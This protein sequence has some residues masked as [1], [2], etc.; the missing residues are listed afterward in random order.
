MTPRGGGG[1]GDRGRER[2]LRS[3]TTLAELMLV[4]W[5]FAFVLLALARFS[6][7]QARLAAATAH[8]LRAEEV[9][10]VAGVVLGRELRALAV[11]DVVALSEDSVRIRAVRG[12]GPVCGGGGTDLLVRYRGMRRPE[13]EKDSLLLVHSGAARGEAFQVT[14]V[15][16]DPACAGGLRITLGREPARPQGMALVF[17]T[18]AYSLA[19]GALRY[20][21][22]AGGRQ[23]LTEAVLARGEIR[24]REGRGLALDL[25]FRADS[26][27]R[28]S[29]TTRLVSVHLQHRDPQ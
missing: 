5:L 17:E 4:A 28:L 20:R 3:G 12:G 27:H 16:T 18:G 19:G 9:V 29:D 7:A 26:L 2:A 15:A 8:R 25:R 22:G 21:R 23:P 14:G 1:S 11:A 13:P 6:S 10:R 24:P